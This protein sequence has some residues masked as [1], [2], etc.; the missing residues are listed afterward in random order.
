[1]IY[2]RVYANIIKCCL[3]YIFSIES[4]KKYYLAGKSLLGASFR[5]PDKDKKSFVFF[6]KIF[7]KSLFVKQISDK[8]ACIKYSNGGTFFMDVEPDQKFGEYV[9]DNQQIRLAHLNY[10]YKGPINGVIWKSF[11]LGYL[12]YADKLL[13]I[14]FLSLLFL[15]LL[16]FA[17][18]RKLRASVG[19]IFFEYIELTNLIPLIRRNLINKLF[20]YSI[21]EKDANMCAILLQNMGVEVNKIT[22]LTPLKIWNKIIIADVLI[23]SSFIQSEEVEKFKDTMLIGR[24]EVWGPESLVNIFGRYKKEMYNMN[25]KV[26][27]FYSTCIYIRLAEGDSAEH[28]RIEDEENAMQILAEYLKLRKDHKLI[29]F[30]HPRER[31]PK[32]SKLMADHYAAYFKETDYKIN[33]SDLPSANSFESAD[34]GVAFYSS[35]II[36]R[37]YCGFKCLTVTSEQSNF[38]LPDSMMKLSATN[39]EDFISKMD[40]FLSVSNSEYF[41]LVELRSPLLDKL[42]LNTLPN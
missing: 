24:T 16:P 17:V 19:L 39:K 38:E 15:F 20:Y 9:Q 14:V 22:S 33:D 25:K 41:K 18:F 36:E 6:L 35:T 40:L 11:L 23:L 31:L 37:L 7:V 27:G 8:E 13:Q 29:I 42:T 12:T 32:Y 30:P 2:F 5:Y 10:Y 26:I 28:Y 4:D 1:M 21:Y 34:L 3:C